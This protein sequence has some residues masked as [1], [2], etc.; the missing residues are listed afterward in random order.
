MLVLVVVAVVVVVVVAMA[1]AV[2]VAMAVGTLDLGY[3][4]NI[5]LPRVPQLESAS[6]MTFKTGIQDTCYSQE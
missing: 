3:I 1:M 2:S 4:R 6:L 5:P